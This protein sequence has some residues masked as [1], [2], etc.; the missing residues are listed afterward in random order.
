MS[1]AR[2]MLFRRIA[3]ER[4]LLT[5]AQ[6][7]K[8]RHAQM[9]ERV[10][11]SLPIVLVELGILSHRQV[12]DALAEHRETLAG[13]DP[14]IA[15]RI[16]AWRVACLLVEQEGVAADAVHRALRELSAREESRPALSNPE[17]LFL[18]QGIA[19]ESL[20]RV[21]QA[22]APA[23]PV[24]A[25]EGRRILREAATTMPRSG[26]R[27]GSAGGAAET[28]LQPALAGATAHRPSGKPGGGP[29]APATRRF[30]RYDLVG[31][32]GR[33][34]MGIVY[35][36]W[37]PDLK[38][39][40][41]LKV[42]LAG[43]DAA[44]DEIRRFLREAHALARLRHPGIVGI[45]DIGEAEGK[46]Y[47]AME[48][49]EGRTLADVLAGRK[50]EPMAPA[51][52][53]GLTRW[54]AEA[55]EFAHQAGV[56]HRDLKPANVLIDSAGRPRLMDFGLA[57]FEG[58]GATVA[59]R[60]G[61]W[62][63]TPAYMSPEHAAQGM[64]AVD[65]QSDVYQLG[66]ILYEM[67]TGKRPF[68]GESATEVMMRV[69]Q[70]EPPAPRRWRAD[71]DRDAETIT[72]QAMARDKSRRY[73][74]AAD[75]ARDCARSLAGES[76]SAR[77]EPVWMRLRR[78]LRKRWAVAL[79]TLAGSAAFAVAAVSARQAQR[80]GQERERIRAEQLAAEEGRRRLQEEVLRN[81]RRV[82]ETNLTGAL[83]VR[84]AG[85]RLRDAEAGFLEPLRDAAAEAAA[86]APALA[87]PHHRLGRLYRALLRFPEALA[88]QERALAKE[89]D[90]APSLYE[91]AILLSRRIG[92]R[93]GELR[94]E[95]ELGARRRLPGAGPVAPAGVPPDAEALLAR[96]PEVASWQKTVR[97]D[98]ERLDRIGAGGGLSRA[99]ASCARGLYL[100]HMGRAEDLERSFD[101]LEQAIAEESTLEEAYD[102]IAGLAV[103]VQEFPRAV[104]TFSRGLQVDQGYVPFWEGRG[105]ARLLAAQEGER[106][107]ED[108]AAG[109]AAAEADFSKGLELDP[110]R[111][112]LYVKRAILRMATAEAQFVRGG[113]PAAAYQGA[114]NDFARAR[115]HDGTLREPARG[116]G[117]VLHQ[118]GLARSRRRGDPEPLWE[119]SV[120]EYARLQ[121]SFP[122]RV[123]GW[124]GRAL[125]AIDLGRHRRA[126]GGDSGGAFAE[127]DASLQRA[128]ERE[129][130]HADLHVYAAVIRSEQA[131]EK[132]AAG[133]DAGPDRRAAAAALETAMRLDPESVPARMQRGMLAMDRGKALDGRGE[134]PRPEYEQAVED[135]R[136]VAERRPASGDAWLQLG[137]AEESAGLAALARGDEPTDA[138]T[139]AL[140]AYDRGVTA[141][142]A[143]AQAWVARSQLHM[144]WGVAA[145]R[146]GEPA[147][148][149][150]QSALADADRAVARDA[151]LPDAWLQRA[152]VNTNRGVSAAARGGDPEPHFAAAIADHGKTLELAP[153]TAEA[154]TGRAVLVLDA[155]QRR[156]ARGQDPQTHYR[157]ALEDLDVVLAGDPRRADAW[158]L[159]GDAWMG[160]STWLEDAGQDP[161]VARAE[162][163]RSLDRAV[164][165]NPSDA[166][167]RWRRGWLSTWLRNWE[168]A[169]AD[170][171]A[172]ARLDP[173]A[174]PAFA[175]RL[176]EARIG[177]LIE[178]EPEGW[179]GLLA[180][181]DEDLAA[182]RAA[183]A[184]L[185][186]ERALA[187][188]ADP[189]R[190]PGATESKIPAAELAAWLADGH[191]DL[192]ALL[193][194]AGAAKPPPGDAK[195][196][197]D[198]AFYHL[199]EAI[200]LG[201][202]DRPSLE[203]D[204]ALT[205]L[206]GDPRW[207]EC[208]DSIPGAK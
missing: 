200:R 97:A 14:W 142:A 83:Q 27:P 38:A 188:N 70:E 111:A 117:E 84:R 36:A 125:V 98:L 185:L 28:I 35:K 172:A 81:L 32:L 100:F 122:D 152:T 165:L 77:R 31:V 124:I 2:D 62:L 85:G 99:R 50:G 23:V 146:R 78:W 189:A 75:L 131:E 89:L 66:V 20:D 206:R 39:F 30:G 126:S 6:A 179:I 183:D 199:R 197:R 87:E 11:P 51:E 26:E 72:L 107:G 162:G 105:D 37:H 4:R 60:S 177:L 34:G 63:G 186:L 13:A 55:L 56:L 151:Q 182:G 193:A 8:A 52:A 54:M 139:R 145:S 163:R 59:T 119:N 171:E 102:G 208:V 149:H 92:E 157:Q 94:R 42:L 160:L 132:E 129:P 9:E 173:T 10:P 88:E 143:W 155:A 43:A 16:R 167:A 40:Y 57:K 73:R 44:G 180:R 201:A 150:F 69:A 15:E 19:R 3:V 166:G 191:Y 154:R 5:P 130:G 71:L 68:E 138:F 156:K 113:D 91:R 22:I 196:L 96:D 161:A 190:T 108:P 207:R 176:A 29:A 192:A 95:F 181:A 170:F 86:K 168:G 67:L 7:E 33:G 49:V 46:T 175:D 195:A 116:C 93:R 109:Y 144:H 80:A 133:G 103:L 47:L 110:S 53:L 48:F 41:A 18:P 45:H 12:A 134:D 174:V 169:V 104:A 101:L 58:P 106:R 203:A 194:R 82:A 164:E 120:H 159:R 137:R 128:L 115:D 21:L 198:R 148:R 135:F 153:R 25:P 1:S 127:A 147:E 64:S 202:L 123:E 158:R 205:P 114:L 76:I 136:W 65:R 187:L 61:E 24:A 90:H 17:D 79:L 118:W 112:V 121:E 204:E 184:R 140:D 141:H 74:R 178:R